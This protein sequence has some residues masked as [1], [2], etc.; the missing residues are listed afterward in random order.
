MPD[1]IYIVHYKRGRLTVRV[2]E[3]AIN[4]NGERE[5]V[6]QAAWFR[7][8]GQDSLG[9]DIDKNLATRHI[10]MDE[11]QS[12]YEKNRHEVYD[13]FRSTIKFTWHK[14]A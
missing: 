10:L 5:A 7:L 12:R 8:I 1:R 9:K 3:F 4:R 14:V 6:A 13:T 11:I 2:G